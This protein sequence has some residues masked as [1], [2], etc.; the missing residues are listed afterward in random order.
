[1]ENNLLLELSTSERRRRAQER[2]DARGD[3]LVLGLRPE[4]VQL[5][6][7]KEVDKETR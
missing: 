6:K 3:P 2:A 4:H 1:M 5:I 7:L